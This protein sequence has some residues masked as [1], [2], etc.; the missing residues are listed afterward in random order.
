MGV[1]WTLRESGRTIL[2]VLAAGPQAARSGE[3]ADR[4]AAPGEGAGQGRFV[5]DVQAAA[6]SLS[7]KSERLLMLAEQQASRLT[8][9]RRNGLMAYDRSIV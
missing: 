7:P 1:V 2:E 4:G 3:C 9:V 8:G 6:I 5:M